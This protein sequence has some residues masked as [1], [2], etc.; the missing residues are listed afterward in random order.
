M[1]FKNVHYSK[2][3]MISAKSLKDKKYLSAIIS[4]LVNYGDN[5]PV[6]SPSISR[7][8]KLDET[9]NEEDLEEMPEENKKRK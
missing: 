2:E 6:T 9:L 8:P 1:P 7:L 5:E 4:K 3:I